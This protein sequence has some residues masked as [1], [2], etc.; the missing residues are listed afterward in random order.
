MAATGGDPLR[1]ITVTED[2]GTTRTYT[3]NRLTPA[4]VAAMF[5]VQSKTVAIWADAGKL[6]CIR[7][8]GG[9]RRYLADEVAAL[10]TSDMREVRS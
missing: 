2:D 9:H 10:L 7:T 1:K 6:T 5:G 8:A 4:E 3:D